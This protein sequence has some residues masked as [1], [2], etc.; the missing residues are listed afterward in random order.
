M[1][2]DGSIIAPWQNRERKERTNGS[3]F[4]GG[5]SGRFLDSVVSSAILQSSGVAL[6]SAFINSHLR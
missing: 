3:P 5:F 1:V 6:A 2:E 4:L